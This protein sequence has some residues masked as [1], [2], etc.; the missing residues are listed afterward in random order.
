MNTDPT[1][2]CN[3]QRYICAG[4]VVAGD[5]ESQKALALTN[6][7]CPIADDGITYYV[8]ISTT[9]KVSNKTHFLNIIRSAT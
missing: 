1:A 7:D 4:I 6:T 2:S 9:I 8:L 5:L 3:D